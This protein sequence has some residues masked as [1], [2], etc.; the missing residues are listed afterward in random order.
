MRGGAP[1]AAA[2][3][4]AAM[5]RTLDERGKLADFIVANLHEMYDAGAD[6]FRHTAE[7]RRALHFGLMT[8]CK[9]ACNI[10]RK[11]PLHLELA[12]PVQIFGD[13]HGSFADALVAKLLAA[14]L[15]SVKHAPAATLFLGDYVDRGPHGVEVVA[16]LLA[17]KCMAPTQMFLLR[18]NHEDSRVNDD[19]ANYG[20]ASFA[21]QC[22]ALCE[23][24][25]AQ[26]RMLW[27]EINEAFALMPVAATVG[28]AIFACHG[29]IPRHAVAAPAG[30]P[31]IGAMINRLPRFD[32]VLPNAADNAAV[33]DD[34]AFM[35]QLMWNDPAAADDGAGADGDSADDGGAAF[36][37]LGFRPNAPRGAHD[38]VVLEFGDA[39]VDAF[40]A[41]ERLQL[42]V[43]AHQHKGQGVQLAKASRVV[44][45]FS[46]SN[47]SNGNAAGACHVTSDAHVRF[48]R[49]AGAAA[50]PARGDGGDDERGDGG[51]AYD[52]AYD[53]WEP[54]S[55]MP[56][57]PDELSRV[58]DAADDAGP[59]ADAEGDGSRT[60]RATMSDGELASSVAANAISA[61]V[62]LCA[63]GGTDLT[64]TGDS[65]VEPIG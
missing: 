49:W 33:A 6:A 51:A 48:Y 27:E 2:G 29:G 3:F 32:S 10:L 43:R 63:T 19:A 20:S 65:E 42:L 7:T 50:A 57:W 15:G 13:I 56:E 21:A 23:G 62:D 5:S 39:A 61:A 34:R 59:D 53:A 12:L 37:A 16:L 11:E 28:G 35:R 17:W 52:A 30:A 14:P 31:P 55:G 8:V 25:A 45:V 47:Y 22:V 38:G 60:P 18:G 58:G 44:T 46:S 24:D 1:A 41:R 40:F 4:S 26:G 64:L 9:R 36:D 54:R